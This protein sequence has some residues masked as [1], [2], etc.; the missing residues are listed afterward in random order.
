M[1][2]LAQ[3][4]PLT[5][6]FVLAAAFSWWPWPLYAAGLS[7]VPIAGFGPFL[8]AV[9]V[10]GLTRGRT[11]VGGLLRSMVRWRVPL[12]A[13]VLALG[14]P[15]LLS[16]AAIGANVW[17]GA[18]RPSSALLGGWVEIPV[19]ILAILLIPGLGGAWEEPGFRGFALVRLEQRWGAM[20]APLVLGVLWVGWHLPLLLAGQILPTDVLTIIAASVVIAAVFHV[21]GGSVLIAMLLHATNNAVG[22]NFASQLFEGADLHRL[23]WLTAAGWCTAAGVVLAV[24]AGNARRPSRAHPAPAVALGD[25]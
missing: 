25:G 10:L 9:T 1:R 14:L 8:A 2:Q 19:T 21:G 16:G 5:L 7:S 15:L 13:Y 22:G 12:R 24:Q 17:L 18:P 11:G 4:R 3:R 6:F 23:G 20:T